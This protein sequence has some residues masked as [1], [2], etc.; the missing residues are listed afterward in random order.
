M[1]SDIIIHVTVEER[2]QIETLARERGMAVDELVRWLIVD[3]VEDEVENID[4]EAV[5]VEAEF[6]QS[7]R[8]ALA[9]N[10]LPLDELW[11]AVDDE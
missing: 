1:D 8:D 11:K 2:K 4:A 5:D 9:G 3:F 6:R 7:L 10:V